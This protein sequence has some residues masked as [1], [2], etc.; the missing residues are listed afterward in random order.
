MKNYSIIALLL[1]YNITFSQDFT[2]NYDESKI[3][4][5]KLPA[6]LT[7]KNGNEISTS[8]QW[9][10]NRRKEIVS[11]F[12]EY[13]YGKIPKGKVNVKTELVKEMDAF[14][15]KATMITQ[16]KLLKTLCWYDNGWSFSKRILELIEAYSKLEV[17]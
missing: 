14:D 7:S 11:D 10:K 1:C 8:A 3:P 9:E 15:G 6:L 12:E 13:V 2:P 5:Y 4:E 16:D 17:K